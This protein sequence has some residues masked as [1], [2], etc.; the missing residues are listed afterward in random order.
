MK[1]FVFVPLLALGLLSARATAQP[2]LSGT[3]GSAPQPEAVDGLNADCIPRTALDAYIQ[4]SWERRLSVWE[5]VG[6]PEDAVIFLGSSII[7]EG[8]W[9]QLF[10]D[11]VTVNRGIG[12]DTTQGV[13][14]R[15]DGILGLK[16]AKVFIYIGGNDFSRLDEPPENAFARLQT[17]VARL[18]AE[19]PDTELYV[20]TLIGREAAHAENISA[21]N[22]LLRAWAPDSPATLVDIHPLFSKPDGTIDPAYSNDDIHL[23]GEAYLIWADFIRAS[24][25]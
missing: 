11:A 12:A 9:E 2:Q 5:A 7:E 3:S 19:L 20:Q 22:R 21:Y 16:P 14:D 17:I 15:L 10:P 23:S 1:H 24:V 8:P 25:E 6:A 13:L 4:L 18:D